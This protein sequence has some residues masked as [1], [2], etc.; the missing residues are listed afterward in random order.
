MSIKWKIFSYLI[1]FCLLLLTIL[2]VFQTVLL[3]DFYKNIKMQEIA[4]EAS[5]YAKYITQGDMEGLEELAYKKG[6]LYVEIWTPGGASFV[7]SG[8]LPPDAPSQF[9]NIS[10]YKNDEKEVLFQ[11]TAAAGGTQLKRIT[12]K[13]GGGVPDRRFRESIIYTEILSSGEL[14]LAS[15]VI[16][17]VNATVD[18]LRIQLYYISGIMLLLAVGIALL[19]SKR[20]S[21]PI[22]TLNEGAKKMGDG[23]VDFHAEGYKEIAE[24]SDTLQKAAKELMKTDKLRQ[25]LIANVSHDLRTPLALITGY[26]EMIRDLPDENTNEN[27]QVIIDEAKRLTSLVNNLLDLSRLQAGVQDMHMVEFDLADETAKIIDRFKKFCEQEG[28]TITFDYEG[29]AYIYADPD[30][31]AQVIYNF[32]SNAIHHAGGDKRV[33]VRLELSKGHAKLLVT[34]TGEGIPEDR[35]DEIWERYYKLDEVHTRAMVGSGLGLS[36]VKSILSQ[37]PGVEYGVTSALGKGSTFWFSIPL[38][39]TN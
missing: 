5:T 25:E 23:N 3:D 6:D 33:E 27:M 29:E 34:D 35:L 16:S 4:K 39:A 7:L 32:I 8:N 21:K 13:G 19:I 12:G 36:I 20:V 10:Q 14:L 17:P 2:W 37:H 22:E 28:Y 24:L 31:I 15:T 1:G 38:A 30:R 11:E 26:G 9:S 18:T